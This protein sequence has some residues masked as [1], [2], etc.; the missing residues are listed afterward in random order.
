MLHSL[1][2]V[3]SELYCLPHWGLLYGLLFCRRFGDQINE[4]QQEVDGSI[5]LLASQL[6]A[7]TTLLFP[8]Y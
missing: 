8:P 3:G 7:I 5:L 6:S 4:Y 2:D 1:S